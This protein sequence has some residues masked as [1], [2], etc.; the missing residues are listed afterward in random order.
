[1]PRTFDVSKLTI[2]DALKLLSLPRAL[3][4]H[5]D[6]KKE[7]SANNGRFGPYIVHN[8]DFRSLKVPDDV[9]TI[10]L[11]RALEIFAQEKKSRFKFKKK[12]NARA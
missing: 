10:E 11:P 12:D 5:P 4:E 2:T 7:I 9:Y 6:T 3:G 1:V 8:G